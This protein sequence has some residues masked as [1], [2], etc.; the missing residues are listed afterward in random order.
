M[1]IQTTSILR[2]RRLRNNNS[3]RRRRQMATNTM[4]TPNTLLCRCRRLR[5]ILS[6]SQRHTNYHHNP[7]CLDR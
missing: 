3:S 4:A 2:M 1:A 6:H 5:D 7:V